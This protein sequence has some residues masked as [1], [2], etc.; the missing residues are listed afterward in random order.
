MN[1]KGRIAMDKHDKKRLGEIV[2]K[3]AGLNSTSD[4][5]AREQS[6]YERLG[7]QWAR[8]QSKARENYGF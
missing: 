1:Y 3:L 4:L 8:E 6:D 2:R 7:A 5:S